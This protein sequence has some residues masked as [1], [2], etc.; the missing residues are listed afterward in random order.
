[1]NYVSLDGG[2]TKLNAIWFDENLRLLGCARAKGVNATI[3]PRQEYMRYIDECL[4]HL[5]GG[6]P[7]QT[8]DCLYV[9]GGSPDD[10]E[11]VLCGKTEILSISRIGECVGGLLAGRCMEQGLLVISGTGS[12]AFWVE[13]GVSDV[14][15]GWGAIL[16]D[17]GSGVWI[18][19]QAMQA[20]IRCEGGWG[21]PTVLASLV[22]AH[23]GA[24]NLYQL[25]DY[26]YQ[27]SA[28]FQKL[29]ALLPLVAQAAQTG[30]EMAVEAFE[31]G[32]DALAMQALAVLERNGN[33][34]AVGVVCG[35]A[36]KAWPRMF[37][38]FRE[39][40]RRIKPDAEVHLPWFE[41][42][43]AGPVKL[44]L[45]QGLEAN[46]IRKRLKAALPQYEWRA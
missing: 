7:P 11:E 5:F 31:R 20:A 26:L 4:D 17:E 3:T 16:G 13:D 2:G 10:Y 8:L 45:D 9:V 40:M 44:L 25:V 37:E 15:G 35:G 22:K 34:S 18:A 29:G 36:W 12:D 14:V 27:S 1:M 46:E 6:C 24:D 43:M 32:A 19:R 42:V 21:K 39:T 41:H 23:L 30:D 33:P 38:R 28:P